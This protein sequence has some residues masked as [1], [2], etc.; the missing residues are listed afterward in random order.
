MHQKFIILRQVNAGWDLSRNLQ[1]PESR[2]NL[3][4][5]QAWPFERLLKTDNFFNG[6]H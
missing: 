4:K 1:K 2:K 3:E 5:S 6:D